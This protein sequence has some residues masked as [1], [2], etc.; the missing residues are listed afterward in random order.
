MLLECGLNGFVELALKRRIPPG[1]VL[2]LPT[3][4]SSISSARVTFDAGVPTAPFA[5]ELD[6]TVPGF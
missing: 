1:Y 3:T 6:T 5:D 4:L 2:R